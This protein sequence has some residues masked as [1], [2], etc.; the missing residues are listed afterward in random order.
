MRLLEKHTVEHLGRAVAGLRLDGRAGEEG[1]I[2]A[3]LVLE[4]D[5]A[6]VA[7]VLAI[8]D[9]ECQRLSSLRTTDN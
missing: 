5:E 3:R 7:A 4:E 2:L 1:Q 9:A 8:A 6:T